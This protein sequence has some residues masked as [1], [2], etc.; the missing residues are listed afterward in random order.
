MKDAD[1]LHEEELALLAKKFR[2]AAGITRA[3][4]ARD[5]G[6]KQ[7]SIFHAEE[8]P[9]LP[10]TKL[11]RRMIESYSDCEIIGPVFLVRKKK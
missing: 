5:M 7:P 9:A 6:V 11:R 10:Y 3:Q 4:A 2:L 8:S 1:S